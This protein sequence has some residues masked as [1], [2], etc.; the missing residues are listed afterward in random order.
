[1]DNFEEKIA[2]DDDIREL[3]DIINDAETRLASKKEKET[4]IFDESNEGINNIKNVLMANVFSE[5][6]AH[7]LLYGDNAEDIPNPFENDDDEIDESDAINAITNILI[8]DGLPKKDAHALIYD[9]FEET[10]DAKSVLVPVYISTV[11]Y[12]KV[13]DAPSIKDAFEVVD[14]TKNDIIKVN[15]LSVLPNTVEIIGTEEFV[16]QFNSLDTQNIKETDVEF[17]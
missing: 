4:D 7:F 16:K 15:G 10:E 14:S 9:D 12:V 5:E 17:K 3:I 6:Q 2:T 8:A 1:M 13:K 11:A